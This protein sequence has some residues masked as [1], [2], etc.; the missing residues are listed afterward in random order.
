MR[1]HMFPSFYERARQTV[2]RRLEQLAS[3]LTEQERKSITRTIARIKGEGLIRKTTKS[4]TGERVLSL[5]NWAAAMLRSRQTADTHPEHPVLPDATGDYRDPAN[6]RRSL[7][8]ALS[9]VGNTARHELGRT[10]QTLRR[11][12]HLSRKQVAQALDWPQ[13][14]LELIETGR[15]KPTDSSPASPRPTASTLT[16]PPTSSPNSRKPPNPPKPTNS[17]G[18]APMPSAKPPP[19]PS[20]KPA[21]QPA[22]SPTN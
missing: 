14:R 19:P 15:I 22:K 7:R 12:T 17:P 10:L 6:T 4:R 5:P 18:S 21:K 9:P 3:R 8:T 20:T 13:T 2:D 11:Q 1:T 16:T